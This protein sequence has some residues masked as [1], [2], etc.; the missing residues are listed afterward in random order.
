MPSDGTDITE[1][2]FFLMSE[3][4]DKLFII[5]MASRPGV[6]FFLIDL[7]YNYFI[8]G[9]PLNDRFELFIKKWQDIGWAV[10]AVPMKYKDCVW[11]VAERDDMHLVDGTPIMLSLEGATRFPLKSCDNVFTLENAKGSKAYEGA[12]ASEELE[13]ENKKKGDAIISKHLRTL[14]QMCAK[15]GCFHDNTFAKS[16]PK[17]AE[18]LRRVCAGFD[19]EQEC[20]L[21]R[22]PV[23]RLSMGGPDICPWC[24][25]GQDPKTPLE[26]RHAY[27]RKT[28]ETENSS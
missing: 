15:C 26:A 2:Q 12:A 16:H 11:K 23:E 6:N 24:D 1:E 10:V 20:M 28:W 9:S 4:E 18:Q 22:N 5:G 3:D 17:E 25:S 21:C 27:Y 7:E 19:P 13:R 14:G 8:P